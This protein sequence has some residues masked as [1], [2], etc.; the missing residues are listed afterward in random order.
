MSIGFNGIER[1]REQIKRKKEEDILG[2][3]A[4]GHGSGNSLNRV[5]GLFLLIVLFIALLVIFLPRLSNFI[6]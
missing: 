6:W 4:N 2:I 1:M 5:I 3:W